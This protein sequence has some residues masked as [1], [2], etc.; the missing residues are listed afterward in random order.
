MDIEGLGYKTIDLLLAE[1]LVADPADIFDLRVEDLIDKEG[2]GEVSAGNL[3]RAIDGARDR[4]LARLLAAL[5]IPLVGATVAAVLARRFLDIDA[6]AGASEDELSAVDGVGPEIARSACSWFADRGNRKLVEK[7][8]SAEVRLL[9]PEPTGGASPTLLDG[10]TVVIT[11]TLEGFSRD[12]A[13]SAVADRGGKV[14]GSVSRNTDVVVAGES[15]GSKLQRAEELGIPILDEEG[16][17]H[18][19]EDGDGVLHGA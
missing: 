11:G 12:E 4:P 14:T 1:D 2:W 19:L 15:P 5:G 6:I 10:I 7:L 13:R 9:D 18:L 8:R 3:I 16:F 17:R